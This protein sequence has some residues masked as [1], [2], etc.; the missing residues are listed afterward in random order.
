LE[1]WHVPSKGHIRTSYQ[2]KIFYPHKK[3]QKDTKIYYCLFVSMG[4]FGHGSPGKKSH[5]QEYQNKP[6]AAF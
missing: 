3:G 6:I 1:V 5:K 4:F 2:K